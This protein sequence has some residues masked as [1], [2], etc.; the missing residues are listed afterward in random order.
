[1]TVSCPQDFDGYRMSESSC[2]NYVSV[3][4]NEQTQQIFLVVLL[5]PAALELMTRTAHTKSLINQI[6]LVILLRIVSLYRVPILD[7]LHQ[8]SSCR[9]ETSIAV[10]GLCGTRQTLGLRRRVL[11]TAREAH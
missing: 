1:L 11:S 8:L 9:K 6:F 2:D 5:T 10:L 4:T 7:V 3:R